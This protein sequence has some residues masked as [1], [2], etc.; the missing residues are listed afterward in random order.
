VFSFKVSQFIQQGK[1]AMLK[2]ILLLLIV[3]LFVVHFV[4]A[5]DVEPQIVNV[6]AADELT[7]MGDFYVVGDSPAPTVLLMHMLGSQRS[8]WE[9]LIPLLLE[10]GF[11]VL[12]VDLRGHGETG[13]GTDW[14]AATVDVQTWLDWLREQPNVRPEAVSVVGASIGSNLALIGCALDELCVTA[15]ALSPGTDYYGLTPADSFT[16]LR[17]RSALLVA[18]HSDG[19]SASSVRDMTSSFRGEL[20]VRLYRGGAH[21]TDLFRAPNERVL[22]VIVEWL[23]EH[24]PEAEA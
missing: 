5:Q 3:S 10:A 24:T 11:N 14:E 2:K 23:V 16:G 1:K 22:P 19:Y 4:I 9:P 7:L 6:T 8:A 15:I 12:A 21:G 18:S 13:G 20:G 17:N